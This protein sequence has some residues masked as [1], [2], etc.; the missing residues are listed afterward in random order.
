VTRL[1]K[2]KLLILPI[3]LGLAL[4]I[5]AWY[6]SYPL[7]MDSPLDFV[8][9]HISPSYWIGLAILLG[10]LYVAATIV[11]NSKLRL[12]FCILI[13]V[14]MYSVRFFYYSLPSS[15][16]STSRGLTE[17]L[18]ATHNLD[19][20]TPY[21]AYFQWPSFFILN[22][23]T[24]SVTGL[25]LRYFEFVLF[26]VL[27]VIYVMSLYVY[28]AKFS[29]ES[30][31][32]AV[33]AYFMMMYWFLNYQFA[34]FSLALGLLFTMFMLETF[35]PRR[36]EVT[37]AT[38][39]LFISATFMHPF[40]SVFFIGYALAM[41]VVNRNRRYLQ[42][43]ALTL[44]IY[45]MM[46]I[47]YTP[48]FFPDVVRQ[49]TSLYLY[50]Y[51]Q[52]VATSFAGRVIPTPPIDAIAETFSRATVLLTGA[53]A[54]SGFLFLLVKRKLRQVDSAILVSAVFYSLAGVFLSILGTRA[55]CLIAVPVVLG[56]TFFSKAKYRKY[57]ARALFLVLLVLFIF[58]LVTE[59]F[60]DSQTFYQT[61]SEY[62][63]AGFALNY[64][65][66]TAQSSV[67]S[68]FRF[69]NYLTV[70]TAS[71]TTSFGSDFSHGFPE[72]TG[73]YDCVVYTIGLGTNLYF[74]NYSLTD[75]I[76]RSKY[77]TI[78]DSYSSYIAIKAGSGKP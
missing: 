56:V 13:V 9:N 27:G 58:T 59:S 5:C 22:Q 77:N 15:D 21:H 32:L 48:S 19:P 50:E 26:A 78:F 42:L 61:Q 16:A 46:L 33:I 35:A 31:Y 70:K 38:I 66:W 10:S 45:L 51:Q 18:I 14:S 55:W 64:Y 6:S 7:S 63:C 29:R 17:Y 75:T 65:N 30:S 25:G 57:F 12:I 44:V 69:M 28:A 34:P 36:R 8:F 40:V 43:F 47:F 67:L 60:S 2:E 62:Q 20:S 74:H 68:H 1:K 72:N 39:I 23:M 3:C 37:L 71:S 73:N 76:E 11:K 49:L 53:I 41:Y 54:G 24:V 4:I 52:T